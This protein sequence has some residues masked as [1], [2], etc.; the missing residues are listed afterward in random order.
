MKVSLVLLLHRPHPLLERV[1]P[2]LRVALED[3]RAGGYARRDRPCRAVRGRTAD[4]T[5]E[6]RIGGRERKHLALAVDHAPM[7]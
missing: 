4:I 5:M 3:G 7:D 1:A 6:H 2:P